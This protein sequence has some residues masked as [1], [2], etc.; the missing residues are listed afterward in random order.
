MNEKPHNRGDFCLQKRCGGRFHWEKDA[1]MKQSA[2]NLVTAI[3]LFAGGAVFAD[4]TYTKNDKQHSM[5]INLIVDTACGKCQFGLDNEKE[6]ILAVKINSEFYYVE[7]TDID[8]HGDAHAKNGFCNA[9]RKAQVKGV[10]KDEK[11][12]LEYF[13]LFEVN[14]RRK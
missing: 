9:I 11:F 6:C 14:D 8:D 3:L 12:F 10:I 13:K 1:I 5:R 7:E 2:I 4:S